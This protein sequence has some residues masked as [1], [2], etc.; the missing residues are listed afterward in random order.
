M[1]PEVLVLFACASNHGCSEVSSQYFRE[2]PEVQHQVGIDA[3]RLSNFVGKTTVNVF[4]PVAFFLSGGTSNI[5]LHESFY[6]QLNKN[7]G[8]VMLKKEF[9]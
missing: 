9:K 3:R 1:L 5:K 7:Q 8:M 4:A 6:L 2:H